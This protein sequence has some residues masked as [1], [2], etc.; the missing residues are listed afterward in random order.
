MASNFSSSSSFLTAPLPLTTGD[1]VPPSLCSSFMAVTA[2]ATVSDWLSALSWED[3]TPRTKCAVE[4]NWE[5][6]D[7]ARNR[8]GKEWRSITNGAE[9]RTLNKGGV[10][11]NGMGAKESKRR[12]GGG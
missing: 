4:E 11:K 12:D 2:F 1:A 5:K 9:R 8:G 6:E 3:M 10:S 7:D